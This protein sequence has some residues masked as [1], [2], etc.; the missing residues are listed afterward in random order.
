MM[1]LIFDDGTTKSFNELSLEDWRR[2]MADL[3]SVNHN[4]ASIWDIMGCVRGPDNPSEHSGMSS[5]EH[6]A[7][8]KGR[9]NRKFDTV[10]VIREA[11]FFGRCGGSAR[12]HKDTKVKVNPPG[13]QDHFDGH[14]IKAAKA[15]G[16]KVEYL[17]G[18]ASNG[19]E[20]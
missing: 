6:A 16:L 4:A 15:L 19:R 2:M 13:F 18:D 20:M 3:L 5:K 12:H 14:V 1:K 10:E 11:M 8:Y 7:A 9:R 17:A